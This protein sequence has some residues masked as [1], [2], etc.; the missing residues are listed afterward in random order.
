MKL[1]AALESPN[2]IRIPFPIIGKAIDSA[3]QYQI[4]I[5]SLINGM[6]FSSAPNVVKTGFILKKPATAITADTIKT[7]RI[8][9][10]TIF[11]ASL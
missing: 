1:L 10:V 2:E 7:S 5:Y 11:S 4:V 9:W 3:P 6:V 8:P